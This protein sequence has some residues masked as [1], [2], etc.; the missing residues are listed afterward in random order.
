[1]N[2]LSNQDELSRV[3]SDREQRI[4]RRQPHLQR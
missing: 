3:R 2:D 4:A 1:L